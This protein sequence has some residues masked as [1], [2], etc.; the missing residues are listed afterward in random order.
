[1]V[2]APSK[3]GIIKDA[4]VL[5]DNQVEFRANHGGCADNDGFIV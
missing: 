1:M 2:S 3:E 5:V 4:A